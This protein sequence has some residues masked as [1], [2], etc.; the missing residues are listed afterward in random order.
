VP[1]KAALDKN[2]IDPRP[3]LQ[4]RGLSHPT[5]RGGLSHPTNEGGLPHVYP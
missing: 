5:Q 2:L 3:I 1:E 4:A